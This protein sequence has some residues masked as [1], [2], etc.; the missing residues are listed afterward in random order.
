[1]KHSLCTDATVDALVEHCPQLHTLVLRSKTITAQAVQRLASQ[2]QLQ[3]LSF[4]AATAEDVLGV[5]QHCGGL[6]EL[7]IREKVGPRF[8]WLAGQER[9]A[10]IDWLPAVEKNCHALVKLSVKYMLCAGLAAAR[11]HFPHLQELHIN[12]PLDSEHDILGTLNTWSR[13]LRSFKWSGYVD[14]AL[15]MALSQCHAQV[16]LE[17]FDGDG[18]ISK[19]AVKAVAQS[20][21]QLQS[22]VLPNCTEMD[23]DA[24]RALARGCRQ[25]REFAVPLDD[26]PYDYQQIAAMLPKG[27]A[28]E[29]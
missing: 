1:M 18:S 22:L 26:V 12:R 15:I 10:R 29:W 4:L 14:D 2:R 21:P 8:C 9:C 28:I 17:C 6:K 27:C 3:E 16:K 13:Q 20:C 24:F 25:L 11:E 23:G 5:T 19:E 7:E